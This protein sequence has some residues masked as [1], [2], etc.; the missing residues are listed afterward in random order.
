MTRRAL[1]AFLAL[2]ASLVTLEG[3]SS[4]TQPG[5]GGGGTPTRADELREVG[6][7]AAAHTAKG[8]KVAPTAAEL[9]GYEATFPVA[10]K[11]IKAGD[12]VVLWG[13]APAAEGDVASGKAGTAV[14]AYE[15]KAETEGGW[16]LLQS[17]DA[18]QMTADEF[19]AAPK[20]R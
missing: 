13:A 10:V 14:V 3:C 6:S 2:T 1:V 20:A 4:G 11:A 8:R 9:A 17:G 18:K 19:K 7:L 5:G 15:K 12:V 16:V